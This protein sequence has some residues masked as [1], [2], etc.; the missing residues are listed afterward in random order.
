[1]AGKQSPRMFSTFEQGI[2]GV[3]RREILTD[4]VT[5]LHE[6]QVHLLAQNVLVHTDM[7]P[8]LG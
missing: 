2:T 3:T 1:M 4:D 6:F 5:F 7:D 8:S